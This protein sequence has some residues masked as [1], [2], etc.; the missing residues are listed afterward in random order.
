MGDH[1]PA[2]QLGAGRTCVD[3]AAGHGHFCALL[4]NAAVKCW[5]LNDDGRLGYEDTT[6]RGSTSGQMGDALL[7]VDLGDNCW[8]VQLSISVHHSCVLCEGGS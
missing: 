3:V 7:A 8:P 5:G 6:T 2:V 1:L 4:D